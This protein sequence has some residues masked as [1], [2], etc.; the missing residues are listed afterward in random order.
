MEEILPKDMIHGQQYYT[1]Y[2]ESEN[3]KP[4]PGQS[5]RRIGVFDKLKDNDP[6][7]AIFKRYRNIK[8][9]DGTLGVSGLGQSDDVPDWFHTDD[10][11]FYKIKASDN[12]VNM[13]ERSY[14]DILNKYT[15]SSIANTMKSL[16]SHPDPFLE[17]LED[18][19]FEKRRKKYFA[20]MD[21]HERLSQHNA[22]KK[23]IEDARIEEEKTKKKRCPK[24]TRRNKLGECEET[25]PKQ[26]PESKMGV[27]GR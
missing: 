17:P 3:F 11:V 7:W 22:L 19:I 26:K 2:R 23:R 9:K 24:G 15:D 5:G 16:M 20:D 10:F 25:K 1:Q 8:K 6:N 12:E 27:G 13:N 18:D 4:G 21:Y 14:Q